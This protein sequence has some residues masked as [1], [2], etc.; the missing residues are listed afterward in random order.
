MLE[1]PLFIPYALGTLAVLQM[2][3]LIML[4][5][6]SGR[7]SRVVR[8]SAPPAS[9]EVAVRKEATGNSNKTFALFLA[10]D[11]S[12]EELPKKE[13]SAAYR[14]WREEKGMNWKSS[15]ESE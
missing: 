6:L 3:I 5:R 15:S 4:L 14:R 8:Q 2:F 7:V 13:Q 9:R 12:R 10:E 1:N 11:P